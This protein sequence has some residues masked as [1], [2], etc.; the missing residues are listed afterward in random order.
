RTLCRAAAAGLGNVATAHAAAARRAAA[1]HTRLE[2]IGRAGRGHAVAVFGRVAHPG[3]GAAQ[4]P[5]R[6]ARATGGGP[7]GEDVRCSHAVAAATGAGRAARDREIASGAAAG[8][9]GHAL[10]RTMTGVRRRVA[11]SFGRIDARA[12]ATVASWVRHA[13]GSHASV[14]IVTIAV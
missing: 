8:A 10:T 3:G 14:A 13:R 6:L 9:R 7:A 4:R 5:G 2:V 12:S 11:Q 1:H